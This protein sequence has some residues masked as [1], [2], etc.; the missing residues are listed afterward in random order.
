MGHFFLYILFSTQLDRFY[1][2][3]TTLAVQKR[4]ENHINKKYGGIVSVFDS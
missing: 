2:G 3:V 4:I 1:T